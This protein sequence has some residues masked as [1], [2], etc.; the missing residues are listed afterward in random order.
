MRDDHA[1][2]WE[3][4][5]LGYHYLYQSPTFDFL[6]SFEATMQKKQYGSNVVRERQA[7]VGKSSRVQRYDML[8]LACPTMG[9]AVRIVYGSQIV[10]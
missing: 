10:Q 6:E 5:K 9:H 1:L 4:P 8:T 7:S 3:T 2:W